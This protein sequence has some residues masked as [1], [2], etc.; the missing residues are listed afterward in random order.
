MRVMATIK[1][2]IEA[3]S[4]YPPDMLVSLMW[5]SPYE[6]MSEGDMKVV[7]EFPN[8]DPANP[9]CEYLENVLVIGG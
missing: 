2:W 4:E 8:G 6:P 5:Y 1:D 3:L 7:E 9:N